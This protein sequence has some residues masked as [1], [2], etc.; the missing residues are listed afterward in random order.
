MFGN[1]VYTQILRF[2]KLHNYVIGPN[3]PVCYAPTFFTV[4]ANNKLVFKG[5]KQQS[6]EYIERRK[7]RLGYSDTI[8]LICN[9]C[10]SRWIVQ[11]LNTFS[12][13]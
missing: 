13:N 9:V 8:L 11:A 3:I 5:T 7:T 12:S 1:P 2:H 6:K 10:L 4:M